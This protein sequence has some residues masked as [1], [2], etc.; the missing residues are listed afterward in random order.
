M[1]TRMAVAAATASLATGAPQGA[2]IAC[3]GFSRGEFLSLQA[4][5][6]ESNINTNLL[7]LGISEGPKAVLQGAVVFVAVHLI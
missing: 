2:E 7:G 1:S 6:L 3:Y 5:P 4:G